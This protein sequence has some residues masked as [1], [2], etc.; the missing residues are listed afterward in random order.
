M[1]SRLGCQGFPLSV[2]WPSV[3]RGEESTWEVALSFLVSPTP[4]WSPED[5]LHPSSNLWALLQP[6]PHT[7]EEA[8][9]GMKV[10]SWT[11]SL[12]CSGA[13]A[14][15]GWVRRGGSSPLWAQVCSHTQS[16]GCSRDTRSA[17]RQGSDEEAG[18]Q[19]FRGQCSPGS[20]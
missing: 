1:G 3:G 16:W 6:W 11:C 15:Q 2:R 17:G 4:T 7:E 10:N 12:G 8:V 14:G 9:M 5:R 19:R 18:E 20:A 13:E